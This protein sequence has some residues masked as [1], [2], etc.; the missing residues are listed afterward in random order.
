MGLL[1]TRFTMEQDFYKSRLME[2]YGIDVLVPT[3]PERQSVHDIIYTELCLGKINVSSKQ[4]YL[5]VI[6]QLQQRGAEAVILGCTEIALLV[7][8][9]DTSMPLYDTTRIHALAAVEWALAN[10]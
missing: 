9:S 2:K 7:E 5:E 8:Q 4:R 6:A 10:Q 3:E 1:G